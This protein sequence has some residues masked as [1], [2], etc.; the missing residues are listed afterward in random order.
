MPICSFR[1]LRDNSPDS[2]SERD[3]NCCDAGARRRRMSRADQGRWVLLRGVSTASRLPDQ[4]R[5]SR[6]RWRRKNLRILWRN[7]R[8]YSQ[9]PRPFRRELAGIVAIGSCSSVADPLVR[10]STTAQTNSRAVSLRDWIRLQFRRKKAFSHM[11][12]YKT[13]YEWSIDREPLKNTAPGNPRQTPQV[14]PPSLLSPD[15]L[16]EGLPFHS[17]NWTMGKTANE[18]E[19]WIH[20]MLK[21]YL[22]ITIIK[23][24]LKYICIEN[25]YLINYNFNSFYCMFWVNKCRRDFFNTS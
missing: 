20:F 7:D 11:R 12:L 21:M 13:Q 14:S 25:S 18:T 2:G 15:F 24:I 5:R 1:D 8:L 23:Y 19:Y 10:F 9:I 22:C 4:C 16:I 3:R 17:F 6:R